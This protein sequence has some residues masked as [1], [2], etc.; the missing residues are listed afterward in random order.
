LVRRVSA[1][2]IAQF[3]ELHTFLRPRQLLD[4]AEVGGFYGRNWARASAES[5]AA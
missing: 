3:S 1:T 4:D 5:F 2:E